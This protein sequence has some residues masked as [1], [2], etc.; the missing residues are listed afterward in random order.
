MKIG[1][2]SG[3]T[4][5][6]RIGEAVA[7]WAY[8]NARQKTDADFEL[9]DIA[10][11][12]LPLLD[13]PA[14]PSLGQ[15]TKDHTKRWAEKIGAFDGFVFV[16]PEYNRGISGALKNAFDFLFAERKCTSSKPGTSR[17]TPPPTGLRSLFEGS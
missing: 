12:D 4:R 5:P 1:N 16:T 2:I 11:F 8:Q 3:S 10:N 13:E 17:S 15:Y 7:K 14:P 9:V 6:G